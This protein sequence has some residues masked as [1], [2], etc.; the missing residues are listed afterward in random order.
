MT[1]KF[2]LR[3]S[4]YL[5]GSL[6]LLSSATNC[7]SASI[8]KTTNFN[9]T[10]R[11]SKPT[12]A[13]NK[14]QDVVRIVIFWMNG[15]SHCHEVLDNVLP[16]IQDKYGEQLE[17][18][19]VE[20]VGGEEVLALYQL[21]ERMG[22]PKE[23]VGVPFLV[24]GEYKMI[25]FEQ[26]AAELPGLIEKY[27]ISGGANWPD[28]PSIEAVAVEA[29]P[30]PPI[31]QLTPSPSSE[32]NSPTAVTQAVLFNSP[33]CHDCQLVVAQAITPAREKYGDQFE[34]ITIDIVTSEDVEY[35]YQA[36]AAFD[37]Q[38][39][40]IDL[41][42]LIIGDSVLIGEKIV[43]DLPD[44]IEQYLSAGGVAYPQ[45][46]ERTS[47]HTPVSKPPP[48]AAPFLMQNVASTE[49]AEYELSTTSVPNGFILAAWVMFVM[50]VVL[51]Y[52]GFIFIRLV[53]SHST[54]EPIVL[55]RLEWLIP[56]LALVGIGVS[57]YLTYVENQAV[58]AV[59]GPVGDC[60][61]VQSSPYARLFG[62]LPLG[63]LGLA[64]YILLLTTWYIQ[65]STAGNPADWAAFALFCM[66]FVGMLFSLYLTYLELF[67]IK[68]V[69][70]WCLTSAV[71][72]SLILLL[73]LGP[74]DR[75][76]KYWRTV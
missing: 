43:S 4:L 5:V 68:A 76:I 69:C 73:S 67:V 72:I 3:I 29:T 47:I 23:K 40:Q 19:L 9:F 30:S 12:A 1:L 35:L 39:E 14:G 38:K 18:K 36:A 44:L 60:N 13:P 48:T 59:C 7:E 46:L 75:H 21:A 10:G 70:V 6:W 63:I 31:I 56:V 74:A 41:P 53:L 26:I 34:L 20:L 17:I 45:L 62:L 50:V 57:G 49:P 58:R 24:I 28:I 42:L 32:A 11:Q 65:R 51:A 61:A 54:S 15:C 22:I 66:A 71:I 37:L 27:L 2:V 55:R 16:P 52:T 8:E 64:G 25:G 33:G